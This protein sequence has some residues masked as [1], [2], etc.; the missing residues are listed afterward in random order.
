MK[1]TD[2][3]IPEAGAALRAGRLTATDLAR[4]HL[5][6]IAV[7]DPI[8]HAFVTVTHERALADAAR[9]DA[10]LAA[11]RDRGP[12]H[13]IPVAL[14]D[15]VDVEGL[16]TTCASRA[17]PTAPAAA[18]GE[19]ARR[20][21]DAG[22]VLVGKLATYEYALVGP[23]FDLPA[24]P[25]ANPWNPAHSTGGSSSGPAAAVAGGLVR[26][27]IGTDTGGSLRSPAAYCGAV[28]LKPTAGSVPG[29]GIHPVAPTLDTAG[30]VAATVAEAAL[31]LD[32]IAGTGAAAMIG[33]PV[34][35]LR[36]GYARAWFAQDPA[37]MPEVVTA[38]DDA[39]SA[40]SLLGAAIEEVALP[41]Y[42]LLEAAGA[43]ILHAEALAVHE[44]AL[45]DRASAYGRAARQTLLSGACLGP[46]DRERA[47]RLGR[48]LGAEIDETLAR[49]DVILTANTLG[50]ALPFAAFDGSAVWTPMRTLPFNVTGHPALALPAGFAHGLPLGL[51]LVARRG[52]EARLC[53]V[54]HAFEQATDHAAPR[55]PLP[56]A[57]PDPLPIVNDCNYERT[58]EELRKNYSFSG[59]ISET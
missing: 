21:A 18:D 29:D 58:T 19:V 15:T 31:L 35:R 13:G 7:R 10:E 47:L 43:V 17:A 1:P 49:V 5:A 14:K 40:L 8:L 50:T 39:A 20:L 55:P 37:A 25:A 53:Q 22:A 42:A 32:V 52:D 2:L 9:A 33:A 54:G 6:R 44:A 48:T 16:P 56:D 27:A 28:G 38:L 46:G 11:G 24:P 59:A 4:A 41:D 51:Q 45:R 30:P 26:A 23:A 12:L 36:I 34:D 3:T 57:P